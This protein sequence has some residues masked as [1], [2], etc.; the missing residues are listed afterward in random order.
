MKTTQTTFLGKLSRLLYYSFLFLQIVPFIQL[1]RG[2][3][4]ENTWIIDILLLITLVPSGYVWYIGK[5]IPKTNKYASRI[6]HFYPSI[7]LFFSLLTSVGFVFFAGT[8]NMPALTIY[9]IGTSITFVATIVVFWQIQQLLP[10]AISPELGEMLDN[11]PTKILE[12]KASMQNSSENLEKAELIILELDNGLSKQIES[13]KILKDLSEPKQN[14]VLVRKKYKQR[15]QYLEEEVRYL[16][17]ELKR[18]KSEQDKMTKDLYIV[19]EQITK[20]KSSSQLQIASNYQDYLQIGEEYHERI[21][22]ITKKQEKFDSLE[23]DKQATEKESEELAKLRTELNET[24]Q[25]LAESEAKL[26]EHFDNSYKNINLINPDP[27]IYEVKAKKLLGNDSVWEKLEPKHKNYLMI[28]TQLKEFRIPAEDVILACYI[29]VF[30]PIFR[31][32]II[33]NFDT[34]NWEDAKFSLGGLKIFLDNSRTEKNTDTATK[35]RKILGESALRYFSKK[36][37]CAAFFE[38]LREKYKN[39][40][41]LRQ[42]SYYKQQQGNWHGEIKDLAMW[43]FE[44]RK[45]N[46]EKMQNILANAQKRRDLKLNLEL[47]WTYQDA[48]LDNI[49]CIRVGRNKTIHQLAKGNTEKTLTFEQYEQLLL[50]MIGVFA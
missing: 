12:I 42:A 17:I 27:K 11:F 35:A 45:I 43:I 31:K 37:I 49:E 2:R 40:T 50:D 29:Y 7:S 33:N 8:Y 9:Q 20:D 41:Q 16:Q 18:V 10:K 21:D 23:L 39:D 36:I 14:R 48:I 13:I 47:I 38:E 30:E 22:L 3:F 19:I 46:L 28:A 6:F 44:G 1:L 32:V 24:M 25:K 4:G 26:S 34:K 15:V 5:S